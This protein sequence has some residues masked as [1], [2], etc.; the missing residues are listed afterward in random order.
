M[1][2]CLH[3]S[4]FKS[5]LL[6]VQVTLGRKRNHVTFIKINSIKS[7]AELQTLLVVFIELSNWYWHVVINVC[8]FLT[9]VC[10]QTATF[11]YRI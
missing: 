11:I 10:L 3:L 7:F 2:L 6:A 9:T 4:I 1:S 5:N 8:H